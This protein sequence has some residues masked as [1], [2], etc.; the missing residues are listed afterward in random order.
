MN[1]HVRLRTDAAAD[2]AEAAEWYDRQQVGLGVDF[3]NEVERTLERIAMNPGIDPRVRASFRRTLLK[4][5]PYQLI[6]R[7]EPDRILVV[8]LLLTMR[9]PTIADRR[10][11]R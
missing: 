6:Y 5:F 2:L 10:M 9:D 8:A 7:E 3:V 4:R 1:R 11:S